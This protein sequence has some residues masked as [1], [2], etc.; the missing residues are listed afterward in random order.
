MLKWY[1]DGS[2][3]VHWDCRGHRGAVFTMGKG[4]TSSYLR[5]LKANT[6]SLIETELFAADMFKPKML[7]SLHF[8]EVQGYEVEWVGLYQDNIST[9][10][11]IK[12]RK[13][14]SGK[15]TKHIKA[16]FFF[17]KDSVDNGEIKLI[18]CSTEEMWA[19]IMMKPLH[20]TA[21][22]V[23]RAELMSCPVNCE[24]PTEEEELSIKQQPIPAP[25]TVT[26][27]SVIATTF[28]TPQECVGQNSNWHTVTDKERY[29]GRTNSHVR[30]NKEIGVAR[31]AT[32]AWQPGVR[33]QR[34][35]R[36]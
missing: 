5:K 15:K 14:S 18:D 4:A 10:L 11:L 28:K 20:G 8:M 34:I 7:W 23:M 6:R 25:K 17:I 9:Q 27:K 1:V 22:R 19:D 29:H 24:D 33:N 21:L 36:Q 26:W 31:L 2:H 30:I 13:M 35:A 16:K 3:N 32:D 12:N